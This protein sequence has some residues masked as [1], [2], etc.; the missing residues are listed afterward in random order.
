MVA[1]LAA[2][3]D[4]CIRLILDRL[5]DFCAR[6]AWNVAADRTGRPRRQRVSYR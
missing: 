3:P 2:A 6:L 4:G 5:D 1:L